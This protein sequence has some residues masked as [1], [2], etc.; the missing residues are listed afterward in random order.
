MIIFDKISLC[1]GR[2][3]RKEESDLRVIQEKKIEKV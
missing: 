1:A 3:Q 2:E